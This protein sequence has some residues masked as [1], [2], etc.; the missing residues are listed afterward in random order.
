MSYSR[1][2]T[3]RAMHEA[4][5]H[6]GR[7]WFATL[8]Y[9]PEKIP[10]DGCVNVRDPQLW[11]KRL[12]KRV[13][14]LRYYLCAEYGTASDRPHYHALIYG[15]DFVD[16]FLFE[17]RSSG[18]V[19]KSATLE[20]SWS[21]GLTEF[22]PLSWANAAYTVGYVTKKAKSRASK[23]RLTRVDRKTGELVELTPEF[24]N[25]SKNPALGRR[26]LEKYWP[27][28][29]P[30][31]FVL[32]DGKPAEVP[33]Y[34]DRWMQ[35]DHRHRDPDCECDRHR[36]VFEEVRH[37]RYLDAEQ[38]PDEKLLMKEKIHR[39]RNRVHNRRETL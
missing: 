35:Q 33:K 11:L 24:Q 21:H 10:E 38:I 14:P 15:V 20:E 29:Y 3:I 2:W 37:Q 26:W 22:S 28:V 25:M 39:A 32:F 19:F 7:A 36:A 8:T 34:Y 18:V 30:D 5:V 31:D 9:S 12:R 27:E 1:S 6:D 13:G 4:Q 16:R 17:R 23:E